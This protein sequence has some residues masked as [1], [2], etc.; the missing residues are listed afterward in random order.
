MV[1]YGFIAAAYLF[2]L[3]TYGLWKRIV[4]RHIAALFTFAFF[5]SLQT[6]LLYKA[7]EVFSLVLFVPWWL[8]YVE[9]ITAGEENVSR[10]RSFYIKGGVLGAVIFMSYY[11]YFFAGIV[12][13][14]VN[15]VSSVLLKEKFSDIRRAYKERFI[16]LI[17]A[18]VLSSP[19]WLS[20]LASMVTHGA[21]SLQNKWFELY[22]LRFPF[23]MRLDVMS[24]IQLSGL[25]ALLL[26]AKKHKGPRVGL[27]MLISAYLWHFLGHLGILVHAPL[28]HLKINQLIAFLF[29][30]GFA[31]ALFYIKKYYPQYK[32]QINT[33]IIGL[34][35]VVFLGEGEGY[36]GFNKS[37]TYKK[38]LKTT[39]P[40]S[41]L[42][43]SKTSKFFGKVFLTDKYNT[44]RYIPVFYF[45]NTNAHHAHP[46]ARYRERIKFL[47]LVG[48][49]TDP[50]FAA[51]MLNYNTFDR[52][53][54]LWL[55][56]NE[57]WTSDDNF[58]NKKPSKRITLKFRPPVGT[59]PFFKEDPFAAGLF[60][61]EPMDIEF[62]KHFTP[63]QLLVA[64]HFAPEDVR[65]VIDRIISNTLDKGKRETVVE[66][67]DKYLGERNIDDYPGWAERYYTSITQK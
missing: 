14:G 38:S 60:Q 47:A 25:M 53:D 5:L 65:P 30:A 17:T 12:Y 33:V 19:Y 45:L 42:D 62:A 46:A 4:G 40:A 66:S 2:P 32:T 16:V 9:G 41:L 28:L 1:K 20:L 57:I 31:F 13:L 3:L 43:T 8:I 51:W 49:S 6:T 11:Y 34:L 39:P 15:F 56:K 58:P 61:I 35:L 26:L 23:I 48:F 52:V 55:N 37:K 27:L 59:S 64:R 44:N 24:L 21:E 7:Y 54:Y 22:M 50:G 63:A 67:A 29:L 36:T 10:N 18:A